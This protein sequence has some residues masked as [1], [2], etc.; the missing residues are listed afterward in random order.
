MRYKVSR[1]STPRAAR[2]T[3]RHLTLEFPTPY[4]REGA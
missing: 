2:K 3:Q 1:L 4:V